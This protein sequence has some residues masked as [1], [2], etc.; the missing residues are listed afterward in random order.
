MNHQARHLSPAELKERDGEFFNALKAVTKFDEMQIVKRNHVFPVLDLPLK[1][2]PKESKKGVRF[3]IE[4]NVKEDDEKLQRSLARK[5]SKIT[6]KKL[7]M[8]N[9]VQYSGGSWVVPSEVE[10]FDCAVVAIECADKIAPFRKTCHWIYKDEDNELSLGFT[11]VPIDIEAVEQKET[12]KE[13]FQKW[14]AQENKGLDENGELDRC[15]FD[16]IIVTINDREINDY[17]RE[18]MLQ[19][20][21]DSVLNGTELNIPGQTLGLK[22]FRS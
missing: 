22:Q 2:M 21:L 5:Q 19:Q 20:Y 14:F 10:E 3:H 4:Y 8:K 17:D 6:P 11:K 15:H 16:P 7:D 1:E 9:T 18:P 13:R 12:V